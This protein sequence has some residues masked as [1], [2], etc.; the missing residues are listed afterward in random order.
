VHI[1]AKVDYG[2]RALLALADRG[3]PA[4]AEALAEDQGL[5]ARF[6]GAILIDLRRAGIVSSQRGAEGGYRL[7]RPASDITIAEIMRALDGPLAEVRGLR[8][9]AAHYD[10]AAAHLQDV[11]V[12]VRASLRNV[13]ERVSLEDVVEGRLPRAVARLT[14]DPDAWAP[15]R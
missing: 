6:L 9:E 7:A 12:A 5:P 11:W 2:T 3:E 13:L 8:P 10:G 14:E 15:R 1:S 4:T